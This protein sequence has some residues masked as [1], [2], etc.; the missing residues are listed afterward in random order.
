MNYIVLHFSVSKKEEYVTDLLSAMLGEIGFESFDI[1]DLGLNAYILEE[2]LNKEA[3]NK[4][5]AD[6]PL[7]VEIAYKEEK[8]EKQNW[9]EEWEKHFFEP[10]VIA[11]KCVVHSS[12]HNDVPSSKMQIVID[13]KMSF[14]TGHHET[15]RLMIEAIFEVELTHKTV[16]DMGCGTSVLAILASKLGAKHID[17][18]DI[19]EWCVENSNENLLLNHINNVK[20]TQG[21]ANSLIDKKYNVI[22]ANINRNILL[23]DIPIYSHSLLENGLL[24]LSGFYTN[25]I[26]LLVQ[27]AE[28]NGLKFVGQK[29]L[30]N[31]ACLLF[32][33]Q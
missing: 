6:F 13:P 18:I 28:A 4:V 1:D 30:N 31:W 22:F 2:A 5:I 16:L 14:G 8:I 15:T 24:L 32:S 17:A 26:D 27:K 33:K 9:N 20:V 12:F 7:E 21:S 19:D 29:E 23:N 11:D 25:D 3:L 10:I